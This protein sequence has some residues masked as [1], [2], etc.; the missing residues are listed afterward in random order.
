M[1]EIKFRGR[2]MQGLENAGHWIYWGING[3]DMLDAIDHESIGEYTGLKDKNGVEIYEG[4]IVTVE[5][6]IKRGDGKYDD[7]ICRIYWSDND[8]TFF[9]SSGSFAFHNFL[10]VLEDYETEVIGNIY[11]NPELLQQEKAHD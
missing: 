2:I 9:V 3:T 6:A 8:Y 4:D 10:T 11:E 7:D 5:E 1:R